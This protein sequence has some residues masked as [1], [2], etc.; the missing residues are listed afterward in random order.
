[1]HCVMARGPHLGE[2]GSAPNGEYLA[3]V[4]HHRIAVHGSGATRASGDVLAAAAQ[5]VD[6]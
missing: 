2:G 3:G 1:M 6:P 5:V 4:I